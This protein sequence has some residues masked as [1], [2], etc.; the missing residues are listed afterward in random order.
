MNLLNACF[1]CPLKKLRLRITHNGMLW[2][3]LGVLVWA[4]VLSVSV[5][6]PG[7]VQSSYSLI[8]DLHAAE[9][10]EFKLLEV[11]PVHLNDGNTVI[12]LKFDKIPGDIK[13]FIMADPPRV[14]VDMLRSSN[15][16]GQRILKVNEGEIESV[17]LI[18]DD[19][20]LRM[21]INLHNASKVQLESIADGYRVNIKSVSRRAAENSS[22]MAQIIGSAPKVTDA[23]RAKL[24]DVDFR[25]TVSGATSMIYCSSRCVTTCLNWPLGVI[26]TRTLSIC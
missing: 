5:L 14:I 26:T 16:T 1:L 24:L 22:D 25:R 10:S 15:K 2:V 8:S 12:D 21:V 6:A 11:L 20:R 19:K 9:V 18:G 23:T 7:L 17:V 3:S 4:N 13:Q